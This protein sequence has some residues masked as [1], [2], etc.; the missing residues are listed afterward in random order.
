LANLFSLSG[1]PNESS[2]SLQKA[3]GDDLATTNGAEG[4]EEGVDQAQEGKE[5]WF[6]KGWWIAMDIEVC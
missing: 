2:G 4:A 5:S 1:T 6:S 3:G